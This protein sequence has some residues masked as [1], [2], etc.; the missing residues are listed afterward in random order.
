MSKAVV[1]G[2]TPF[3]AMSNQAISDLLQ[4][5]QSLQR[6]KAAAALAVTTE[7]GIFGVATGGDAD[8]KYAINVLSPALDAFIA[9]NAGVISQLDNGN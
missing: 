6:I 2:A 1:N 3:G 8:Y 9:T 5:Q 4:A 7:G